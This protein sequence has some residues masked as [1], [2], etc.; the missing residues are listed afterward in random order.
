MPQRPAAQ[1]VALAGG[2]GGSAADP[3]QRQRPR[4][5]V[6][7]RGLARGPGLSRGALVGLEA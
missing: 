5:M 2:G 6:L 4:A 7:A 1:G 3:V